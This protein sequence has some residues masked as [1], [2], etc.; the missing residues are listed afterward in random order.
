MRI[1]L[2]PEVSKREQQTISVLKSADTQG[3]AAVAVILSQNA[4]VE[5]ADT[6]E[7]YPGIALRP[8]AALQV[9][10]QIQAV[11]CEIAAD[12]LRHRPT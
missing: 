8:E 10:T 3:R 11:L 1:N 7:P 5:A 2:L 12:I 9:I 4:F 6:H